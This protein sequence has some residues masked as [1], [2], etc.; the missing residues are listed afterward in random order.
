MHVCTGYIADLSVKRQI[1]F[2]SGGR[3]D[4]R[5]TEIKTNR[6]RKKEH[7]RRSGIFFKHKSLKRDLVLYSIFE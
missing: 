4:K 6:N 7:Y 1:L 3:S 5:V 2:N